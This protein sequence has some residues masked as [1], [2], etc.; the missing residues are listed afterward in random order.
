LVLKSLNGEWPIKYTFNIY[1]TFKANLFISLVIDLE[2]EGAPQPITVRNKKKLLP[3]V[4]AQILGQCCFDF[5]ITFVTVKP[6][7]LRDYSLF[8]ELIVPFS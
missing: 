5:A 2:M 7:L 1:L 6:Q 4:R 8:L 3:K